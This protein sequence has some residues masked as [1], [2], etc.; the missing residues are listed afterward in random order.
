MI[1]CE[2][3]IN[4]TGRREVKISSV[5]GEENT[6]VGWVNGRRSLIRFLPFNAGRFNKR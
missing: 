1:V 5:L 3:Q 6:R 2:L 4:L